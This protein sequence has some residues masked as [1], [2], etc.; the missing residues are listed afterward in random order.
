MSLSRV[1][2][3]F[4]AL[5]VLLALASPVALADEDQVIGQP[6]LDLYSPNNEFSTGVDT[7][8]N[9]YI[10]NDGKL[11][12]GGPS[13]YVDRVTTARAT[14]IR[15]R[16]GNSPIE[17]DTGRYSVGTVPE[18]TT[19]PIPIEITIPENAQPGT[20]TLPVDVRY[21]YTRIV[22]YGGDQT[23]YSDNSF[24]RT[25]TLEITIRDDARFSVDASATDALVGDRGT[26]SLS[27]TNFGRET[28]YSSSVIVTSSSDE[29]R[30]GTG[31]KQSEG[32]VGTW[33][34]G[35]TKEVEFTTTLTEDAKVRNYTIDVEVDY[36]DSDGI[37]TTSRTLKASFRPRPEQTF[38]LADVRST[39]RVDHEGEVRGTVHNDGPGVANDA[40]LVLQADNP[41]LDISESEYALPDLNPGDSAAF[42]FDVD[43]SDAADPGPR[44]FSFVVRYRNEQG[45]QRESDTLESRVRIDE[46]RDRFAVEPVQ[47]TVAAGGS[48]RVTL[49]VTN[50]GEDPLTDVSAKAFPNE[51]LSSDDDEAFVPR[52]AP[53]E[54]TEITFG[55]SAGGSA[56][57]KVYPL[58]IDFQ[59][60]TPDGE[61]QLSKTY[62]VPVTVTEREQRELPVGMR[63]LGG[64]AVV[65]VAIIGGAIW[66]RRRGVPDSLGE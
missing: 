65:L 14:T 46:R 26:F 7:T 42:N 28:A 56:L 29:I 15:V 34:P 48:G 25:A 8:L 66:Y 51:P 61:T 35:E 40:V 5:L 9:V 52:L 53:G 45:D 36:E 57:P 49:Q 59:Y 10:A 37:A 31:S 32:F 17:V 18:G 13:D 3:V 4:L 60:A 63:T 6:S 44:Q 33:A 19:G 20:Y 22:T 39:L 43:V 62:K 64:L 54:S 21:T 30:F 23:K 11:V 24:S 41:N 1:P 55:L 16:P 38:R 2:P 47:A 58:S 50:N 27:L 12:R